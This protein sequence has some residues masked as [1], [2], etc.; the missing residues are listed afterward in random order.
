MLYGL[1]RLS[2]LLKTESKFQG[3]NRQKKFDSVLAFSPNTAK[4]GRS[5]KV[6]A[7]PVWDEVPAIS[8]IEI[9]LDILVP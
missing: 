8:H 5:A 1:R 6:S 3:A 4:S 9:N 7:G 2:E